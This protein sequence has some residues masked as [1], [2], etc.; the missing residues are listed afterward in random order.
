M[1]E[2]LPEHPDTYEAMDGTVHDL[3]VLDAEVRDALARLIQ[4]YNWH[5][6]YPQ[7]RTYWRDR[8]SPIRTYIESG[9]PVRELLRAVAKDLE[10][11]L[12]IAQ[13]RIEA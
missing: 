12:G 3:S 11:R 10:R 4:F 7:F 2:T 13:G 8:N 6:P 1:L 5:P 9:H